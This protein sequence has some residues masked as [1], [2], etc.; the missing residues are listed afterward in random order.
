[1][2]KDIKSALT[3][4]FAEGLYYN[5]D[6]LLEASINSIGHDMAIQSVAKNMI[7]DNEPTDKIIKYTG[8]TLEVINSLK[9]NDEK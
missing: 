1:M 3:E 7:E 9:E 2:K 5:P 6:E 4:D 8:L